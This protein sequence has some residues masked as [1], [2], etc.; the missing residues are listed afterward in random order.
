MAQKAKPGDGATNLT[1]TKEII[2]NEVP[3]IINL[4][5]KRKELN[6]EIAERRERVN[7]TGVP[8]KALDHAIRIR[9]MDPDDRQQFDEGL[10]IA[11]DAIG[12]PM[13]QSLFD[14]IKSDDDT[15][16]ASAETVAAASAGNGAAAPAPDAVH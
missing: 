10:A 9:Q 5:A 15:E 2:R 11:R 8:K 13:S 12:L 14:F 3:A 16:E 7:A 6:A 4:I 1:A